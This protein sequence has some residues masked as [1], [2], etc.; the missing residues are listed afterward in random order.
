MSDQ[1]KYRWP[2][3]IVAGTALTL[4][5]FC[6]WFEFAAYN[7]Y[8]SSDFTFASG[9]F[10]GMPESCVEAA[11][12]KQLEAANYDDADW[13]CNTDSKK[14]LTNLL[15]AS[16][17][18]LSQATLSGEGAKVLAAVKTAIAGGAA[19]YKIDVVAAYEALSAAVE[20]AST[21]GG[22][23]A[24]YGAQSEGALAAVGS[25]EVVCTADLPGAAGTQAADSG[26]LATDAQMYAH[27]MNQFAYARAF[28]DTGTMTIPLVGK[29]PKPMLVPLI[30]TNSTTHHS[31]VAKVLVGTRWGYASVFYVVAMMATAFFVMDS[32]ILLLAE[33]TRVDACEHEYT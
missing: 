20:P 31:D 11:T 23:A 5:A 9:G 17:H 14:E 13:K 21:T 8:R 22:C 3:I 24:V 26:G 28:P 1:A 7:D 18:S 32:T 4:A 12:Q 6:I 19:T 15:M 29:E 16:A 27:C 30:A 2:T 25:I 10:S 33:L